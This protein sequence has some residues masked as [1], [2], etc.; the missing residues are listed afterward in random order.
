MIA[1]AGA[2]DEMAGIP[3]ESLAAAEQGILRV[4]RKEAG[5]TRPTLV[6][7]KRGGTD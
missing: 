2:I 4:R 7:G 6:H 1:T 3:D 5:D